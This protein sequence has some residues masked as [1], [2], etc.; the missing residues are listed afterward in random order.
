MMILRV[1]SNGAILLVNLENGTDLAFVTI[2][3]CLG[4]FLITIIQLIG[5]ALD[6]RSPIKVSKF[7][8][9]LYYLQKANH[10]LIMTL[11]Y[12]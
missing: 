5:L 4:F 2:M 8:K 12:T 11:L 6:D 1:G 7:R 9:Y 10:N 3:T